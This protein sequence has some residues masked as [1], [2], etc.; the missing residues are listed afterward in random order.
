MTARM[1]KLRWGEGEEEEAGDEGAGCS[2]MAMDEA[3]GTGAACFKGDSGA[4]GGEGL[5]S[6]SCRKRCEILVSNTDIKI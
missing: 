5:R 4:G 3:K 6:M 2:S 1:L